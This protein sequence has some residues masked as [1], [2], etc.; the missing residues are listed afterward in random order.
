MLWYRST[1]KT[2]LTILFV[3][4][5]QISFSQDRRIKL[6][7]YEHMVILCDTCVSNDTVYV[8]ENE[9]VYGKSGDLSLFNKLLFDTEEEI[10]YKGEP[11]DTL[12][13]NLN[14]KYRN[15]TLTITS[16]PIL[17]GVQYQYKTRTYRIIF[18]RKVLQQF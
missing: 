16:K 4:L 1:M 6:D 11:V 2:I 17:E 13:Y 14:S 10:F 18:V 9:S 8:V 5:F 15:K 12:Y 7:R 3:I